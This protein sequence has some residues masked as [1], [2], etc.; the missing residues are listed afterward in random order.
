MSG[1]SSVHPEPRSAYSVKNPIGSTPAGIL[2]K[3]APFEILT[4]YREL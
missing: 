2:A 3:S 1:L 4:D